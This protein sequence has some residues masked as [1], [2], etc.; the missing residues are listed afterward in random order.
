MYKRAA[1]LGIAVPTT[2]YP[3]SLAEVAELDLAY[4]VILKPA[5]HVIENPLSH[6][7]VWRIDDRESLLAR[8]ADVSAFLPAG[9]VM[10]QEIIP[11]GGSCQFAFAAACRDGEAL[12]FATVRR[13]RQIPMDFGR[14]STFV[15]TMDLPEVVEPARRIIADIGLT[16]LVEVEFKR[17]PRDDQLKLLDVNARAWGWHSIGADAGVDFAYLAWRIA[18]G[19]PV[20]PAAGRS[21]VRWVRLWTDLVAS[22]P[23]VFAGRT[24]ARW[25]LATLRRPITGPIAATD[26]PLPALMELPLLSARL[27]RRARSR[28]QFTKVQ[29]SYRANGAKPSH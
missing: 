15:E 17:D 23:E 7:K 28:L 29:S 25:Y 19:E 5:S 3:A 26:D 16:G 4:P 14:A 6:V 20:E 1:S 11:G 24:S 22:A 10:I 12:G 13:T 18:Q 21:G 8:Y 9:E 2:W 27:V